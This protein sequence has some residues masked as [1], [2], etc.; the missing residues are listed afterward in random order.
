[1]TEGVFKSESYSSPEHVKKQQ[2]RG[3]K[4]P[5]TPLFQSFIRHI[6]NCSLFLSTCTFGKEIKNISY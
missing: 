4:G 1:M 2:R 3:V 6:F 5:M